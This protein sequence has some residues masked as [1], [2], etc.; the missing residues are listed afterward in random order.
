LLPAFVAGLEAVVRSP[1]HGPVFARLQ[2]PI[3]ASVLNACASINRGELDQLIA[4]LRHLEAEAARDEARN[5][6]RTALTATRTSEP[7]RRLHQTTWIRHAPGKPE[8]AAKDAC[9]TIDLAAF[10]AALAAA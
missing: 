10:A 2:Q 6:R 9:V 7:P 4:R 1:F 5:F 8:N 3:V